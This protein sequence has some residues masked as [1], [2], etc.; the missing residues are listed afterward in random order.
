MK[1]QEQKKLEQKV[2]KKLQ[3]H[4]K[5]TDTVI[6]GIS[7]GPDSV[8]LLHFLKQLK[9]DVIIAHLNHRLR[10]ESDAEEAF[11][12]KIS[13][14]LKFYSKKCNVKILSQKSKQ[15]LEES[16]RKLRYEFF[17][18]LAKKYQAKLIITAHHA[19]DNLET[20]IFNFV[21]GASLQGLSG[22]K[23]LE[24]K[25]L[26]PLLDIQKKDI[27]EYLKDKKIAF[28]IDKSNKDTKFKRNFIRHKIIPQLE[29]INPSLTQTVTKNAAE[30]RKIDQ[31]LKLDAKNW[32]EKHSESA[33]KLDAKSFRKQ[34]ESLQKNILLQAYKNLIGNTINIENTHLQEIID[35]INKNIGNKKK[36]MGKITI[37]L[38]NNIIG[39]K[40]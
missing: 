27:L 22:M 4:I 2:Q 8:F 40:I 21:R 29:K 24:E 33:T 13:E 14:N 26:R 38:R 10:K 23:E 30:L 3:S 20:I 9:A 37:E 34:H 18:K 39:L 5:D 6:A 32:L 11:V 15:G 1:Q 12:K 7:G 36:K 16:G 31:H 19:D 25:L 35:M 28:K 17:N